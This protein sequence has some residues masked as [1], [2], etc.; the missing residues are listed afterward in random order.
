MS[1]YVSLHPDF[2]TYNSD[3][4]AECNEPIPFRLTRN[5]TTSLSPTLID[6]LFSAVL[7]SIN[8]CLVTNTEVLR[9]YLSLFVRDDLLSWYT[10]KGHPLDSDAAQRA[11]EMGHKEK[12]GANTSQVMKRI[13]MLMPGQATGPTAAERAAAAAAGNPLPNI[14]PSTPQP[15]NHKIH[16]LIKVATNKSKLAMMPPNWAPWF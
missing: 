11:V 6:G 12:V 9:N 15:L 10:T 2:S 3:L 13:H 7:L 5:M 1:V 4:L 16:L 14:V 8:S